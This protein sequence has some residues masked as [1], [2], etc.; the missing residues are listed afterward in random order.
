MPKWRTPWNGSNFDKNPE[1]N[2]GISE[3][4][5]DQAMSIEEIMSRYSKGL[6][7]DGERVPVW[8]QDGLEDDMP[9]LRHMD[10]AE[11]QEIMEAVGDEIKAIRE[12][13]REKRAKE[14]EAREKA[15]KAAKS[16]KAE[17]VDPK[18][19]PKADDT[20]SEVVE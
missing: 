2:S 11:R 14:K 18:N 20:P 15:A 19:P 8:M 5:P 16:Q 17:P 10:L 3:T 12:L 4:V 13:H 1:Y 7:L 9:D 6:P